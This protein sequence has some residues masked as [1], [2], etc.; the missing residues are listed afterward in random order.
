MSHD[1]YDPK[2]DARDEH[3]RNMAAGHVHRE[4]VDPARFAHIPGWGADG[5]KRDRPAVPMERTPPRLA[6]VH[7]DRPPQQ[8]S[9]VEVLHSTERSGM[10]PVFGTTVPPRGVS[11]WLRRMGFRFSENDLR[12]WL[13]L[14][15][16]DRV[17]VVEGLVGDVASGHLPRIYA[18]M[19]G[20]AELKHNPAGAARKAVLLAA[21]AGTAYWMWRRRQRR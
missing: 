14:L 16:A 15:A 5:N 10:T 17:D 2:G 7:W 8:R 13:V 1:P 4:P 11:G 9:P 19:G 18:E 3:E 21:V 6:G 20:R 12:R